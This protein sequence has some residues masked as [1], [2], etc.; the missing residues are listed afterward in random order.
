[1]GTGPTVAE[2]IAE[3]EKDAGKLLATVEEAARH[4]AAGD[5]QWA[6]NAISLAAKDLSRVADERDNLMERFA[7]RGVSPGL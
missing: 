6:C 4:L 5:E 3:M 7:A 2:Y 1:M